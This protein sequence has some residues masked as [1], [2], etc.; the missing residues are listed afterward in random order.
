M[1]WESVPNVLECLCLIKAPAMIVSCYN[2]H[3]HKFICQC[4]S[5]DCGIPNCILCDKV[6]EKCI[7]CSEG[8]RENDEDGGCS[9][10]FITSPH[11]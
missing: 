1:K 9:G 3:L 8:Y 6:D 2:E 7:Q 10:T 4:I 11:H 5:T